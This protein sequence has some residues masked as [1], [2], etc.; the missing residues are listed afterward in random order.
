[1]T[2]V[3]GGEVDVGPLTV[4]MFM[5]LVL[6]HGRVARPF[7]SAFVAFNHLLLVMFVHVPPKAGPCWNYQLTDRAS[8]A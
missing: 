4:V 7:G 5:F 3:S 8:Y 6:F 1:M 2:L